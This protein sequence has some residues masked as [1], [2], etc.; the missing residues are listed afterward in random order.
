MRFTLKTSRDVVGN[1]IDFKIL[2][3]GS[4]LIAHVDTELDNFRLGSD[5]LS[6]PS[7]HFER[8]FRQAGEAGPGMEHT[9]EVKAID[10]DGNAEVATKIW[11]DET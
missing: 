7:V 8:H 5:H 2:P 11:L 3:S 10:T 4:Q 6:E 9:L 1:K